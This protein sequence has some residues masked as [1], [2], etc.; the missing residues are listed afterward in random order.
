MNS[1][2]KSTTKS[3][4]KDSTKK[5]LGPKKI[6]TPSLRDEICESMLKDLTFSPATQYPD[7]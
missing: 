7:I 2:K 1:K 3:I 5:S 6:Q 4:P